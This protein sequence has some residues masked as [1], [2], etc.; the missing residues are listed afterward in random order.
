MVLTVFEGRADRCCLRRGGGGS[1]LCGRPSPA[2]RPCAIGLAGAARASG[3]GAP[4]AAV[5]G[6]Q[7]RPRYLLRARAMPKATPRRGGGRQGEPAD[8]PGACIEFFP[9]IA[10]GIECTAQ[11][12]RHR[13]LAAADRG[14]FAAGSWSPP[15]MRTC[16]SPSQRGA[17]RVRTQGDHRRPLGAASS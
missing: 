14:A 10:A 2:A 11:A 8:M 13:F 16:R 12:G 3:W 7:P 17:H 15:A 6:L 5:A 4:P 9:S 1:L